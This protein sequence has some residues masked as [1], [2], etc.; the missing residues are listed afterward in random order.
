MVSAGHH[1]GIAPPTLRCN[2]SVEEMKR[3]LK[4]DGI[5]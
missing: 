1:F 2:I 5:L 3:R 4:E